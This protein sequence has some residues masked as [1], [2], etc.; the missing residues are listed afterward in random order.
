M[1]LQTPLPPPPAANKND[2]F[3]DEGNETRMIMA[4]L[5]TLPPHN[6]AALTS[7][8]LSLADTR[9]HRLSALLTSPAAFSLALAH[10]HSLSLPQKTHLVAKHL[11]S[12]LHHLTSHFSP[13]PPP[14]PA[15]FHHRDADAALLLLLLCDLLH[16]HPDLLDATPYDHWRVALAAHYRAGSVLS[17]REI[18]VFYGGVLT[19]YV[20]LSSRC[21]RF[22]TGDHGGGEKAEAPAAPAAVVALPSVDGG[23]GGGGEC[24]VCKEAMEEGRDVCEL[25][26]RHLFHWSCILPWLVKRNTCPCCRFQLPTEDVGGEIRRLWGFLV[27]AAGC[28]AAV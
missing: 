2:F 25:P 20:E 16:R 23:G 18:G 8:L 6:L 28:G 9:R 27:D 15:A 5:S 14:P 21:W 4:A 17:H 7:S 24:V 10:L 11:L 12:S 26:C 1:E 3:P 13:P 19:P 22:V